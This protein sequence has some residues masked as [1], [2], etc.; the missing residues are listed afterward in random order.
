LTSIRETISLVSLSVR[1]FWIAGSLISGATLATYVLV[2][3]TWFAV[4]TASTETGA[5]THPATIS[6]AATGVRQLNRRRRGCGGRPRGSA[7]SARAA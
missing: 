7:T 1:A 4:H 6:S 2:S 3:D 5:R